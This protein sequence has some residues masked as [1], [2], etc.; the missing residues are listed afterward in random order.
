MEAFEALIKLFEVP[1][2]SVKITVSVNFLSLSGIGAVMDNKLLTK[3]PYDLE[4]RVKFPPSMINQF[5]P[6]N[7]LGTTTQPHKNFRLSPRNI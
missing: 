1:Q 7:E 6:R 4:G 3:G 5:S 2:R